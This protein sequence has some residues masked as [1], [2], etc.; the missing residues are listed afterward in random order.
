MLEAYRSRLS[1]VRHWVSD[2]ANVLGSRRFQGMQLLRSI[3]MAGLQNQQG[4]AHDPIYYAD[5]LV[6][7]HLQHERV[8][9]SQPP[10]CVGRFDGWLR[11]W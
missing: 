8:Q 9:F 3:A 6:G 10:S 5:D 4:V 7:D 1:V 11:I 2:G